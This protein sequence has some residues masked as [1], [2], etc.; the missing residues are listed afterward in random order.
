M[1]PTDITSH[2]HEAAIRQRV[3]DWAAAISAKDIDAVASLY[4]PDVVSFDLTPP[5]RYAGADG[6]CR[7]WQAV[8]AALSGP[9]AYEIPDLNITSHLHLAFPFT[10]NH[11]ARALLTG[12]V[13]MSVRCT[14]CFRQIDGV[15]FVAHDHVSVPADPMQGKALLNLTP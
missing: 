8:F 13:D 6:K 14:A 5:L 9:I 2:V 11:I 15:W 10:L 3:A 4:A 12:Q 7:A 1:S